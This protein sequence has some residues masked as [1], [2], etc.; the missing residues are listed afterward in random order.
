MY[1]GLWRRSAARWTRRRRRRRGEARED[2][3]HRDYHTFDEIT[4]YMRMLE[5]SYPTHA[6]LVQL[7]TTHEGR[8]ILGLKISDDLPVPT[9]TPSRSRNRIRLPIPRHLH[10]ESWVLW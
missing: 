5:H 8:P 3:W 7:G 9:P 6:Q 2:N 4:A 1:S 10:T